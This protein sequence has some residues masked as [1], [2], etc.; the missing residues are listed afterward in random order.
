MSPHRHLLVASVFALCSAPVFPGWAQSAEDNR[1]SHHDWEMTCDNTRTCRAAGYQSDEGEG[2][3]SVLLT[4]KAG[5]GAAVTALVKVSHGGEDGES[6]SS[7][8]LKL[9][10][11]IDGRTY[12][13]LTDAGEDDAMR[14]NAAQTAALLKALTRDSRIEF[15]S[16]DSVWVLSDRGASAVLLKMDE[17][18]GRV[19]TVGAL[20]RKG[21]NSEA[22]VPPPLP[23]PVVRAARL[24]PPLPGDARFLDQH[25]DA[26]RQALRKAVD[27]DGCQDL[28]E[29]GE[30]PEPLEFVRLTKTK[31]LVSTRCWMAAYNMGSGYWVID[32]RPPYRPQFVTASGTDFEAGVIGAHHKSRGLGDCW[33]SD[34]WTWDGSRFVHTSASHTGEC[35]GFPGGAWELPMLVTNV[36][37]GK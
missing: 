29:P 9:A 3:V 28:E 5:P 32:D 30:T 1:F 22:K 35:K 11:W 23:A 21:K 18:Q 7:A 24:H 13:A 16:P 15:R 2:L 26:L 19:G 33:G 6:V 36:I 17:R 25:G 8:K 12:G 34:E 4:R 14:L 31:G 37:E 27:E 20:H 10:L